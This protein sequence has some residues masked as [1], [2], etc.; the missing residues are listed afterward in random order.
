[1]PQTEKTRQRASQRTD[2]LSTLESSS[3]RKKLTR[4]FLKWAGNKF[5]ILDQ[6]LPQLNRHG[7]QRLLE[8]FVGSGAVFLNAGFRENVLCDVNPDIINLYEYLR[9]QPDGFI[10]DCKQ[11]FSGAYNNQAS[12]NQLRDEFNQ[13]S[14]TYRRALLFV[15][16]NRHCF[17]GLCRYNSKGIFNVPFG[18]YAKP[19]F[20]AEELLTFA[21]A[22][23][24]SK[25]YKQC[26]TRTFQEVRAG[27]V[28]YCDP[29]YIPLSV[30]SS[31]S[32]YSADDFGEEEQKELAR[33][34]EQAAAKG[35]VVVISNHDNEISR[36]LYRSAE[37]ISFDVQRFISA[38]GD[39]R[40][41]APELLA[42]FE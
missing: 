19:Y 4:P 39:R 13:S 40:N 28:V 25:F 12:F 14:D 26:F 5:K 36:N 23:A 42:I 1:M 38:K 20:P 27:D 34:A 9:Q 41:K 21:A 35:A 15:Y 31:F 17:N 22:S 8:P 32:S 24:N 2:V 7:N 33:Q 16:L 3:G 18:R 37:I 6:V 10:E 29:P 11:Y 30:T